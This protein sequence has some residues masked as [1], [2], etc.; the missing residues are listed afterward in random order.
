MTRGPSL[1]SDAT[2]IRFA[3]LA[4]AFQRRTGAGGNGPARAQTATVVVI[5]PP[6]RLTAAATALAALPA[7][8]RTILIAP[9]DRPSPVASIAGDVVAIEGLRVEYLDNA[10]ASLRLS[11]LPTLVWWRDVDSERLAGVAA[12][13]DRL[14]LDAEDPGEVWTRAPSLVPETAVSDLRWTRL[15]RWRALMANFFD[16]PHVQA[17]AGEFEQL[18]VEG[19]D[20]HASRLFAAWLSSELRWTGRVRIEIAPAEGGVPLEGV[21]L[22]GPRHVLDLRLVPGRTCVRTAVSVDGEES[23]RVVSIGDQRLPALIGEE[24]RVRS[25]DLAFERAL[26]ALGRVA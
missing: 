6:T 15:T 25:R 4:G 5:G 21:T 23:V 13:A 19:A 10:L 9:G 1:L 20:P 3:D 8:L 22:G 2:E 17:G 26:A 12:L 7:G 14:V 16:L 11:S 24:L 18:R